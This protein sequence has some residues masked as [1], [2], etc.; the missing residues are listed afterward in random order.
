[1]SGWRVTLR[2]P[3]GVPIIH[4]KDYSRKGVG[5]IYNLMPSQY[6]WAVYL[7]P[8]EAGDAITLDGGHVSSLEE[9]KQILDDYFGL[10]GEY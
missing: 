1:M 9:G 8:G 7:Y 4:R 3:K 5:V 2:D 10:V 6:Y